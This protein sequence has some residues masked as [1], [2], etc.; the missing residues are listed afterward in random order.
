MKYH[1]YPLDYNKALHLPL[2]FYESI[3][4]IDFSWPIIDSQNKQVSTNFIRELC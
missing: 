1:K 4:L 3:H 2:I